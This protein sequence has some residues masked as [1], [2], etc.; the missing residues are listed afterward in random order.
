MTLND[1]SF[2]AAID[3]TP[4]GKIVGDVTP[5]PEDASANAT[6]TAAFARILDSDANV[7]AQLTVGVGSGDLQLNTLS[8][9]SGVVFQITQLDFTMPES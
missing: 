6:G 5:V 3:A 2:A 9:V 4:G 1:P 7:V 8:L